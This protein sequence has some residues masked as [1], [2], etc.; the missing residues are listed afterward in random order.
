MDDLKSQIRK[1]LEDGDIVSVVALVVRNRRALNMLVRIS[2]AKDTLVG[3]RAIIAAGAAAREIIGAEYEFLRET[4]RKLLWSLTDESGGIGWSAP[5]LLGEI[6]SA[7]P[8]RFADLVPLIASVYGVEEDVFRPG[9]VYALRRIAESAPDL[10]APQ[11]KVVISA[12]CDK[13]PLVRIFGLQLV[14]ALW[15]TAR[16]EKAWSPE[17]QEKVRYRVKQLSNDLGEAWV[18]DNNSFRSAIVKEEASK[19]NK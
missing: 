12:L 10:V 19:I 18:Y 4:C 5:E 9:V 1:G 3:W 6:I 8:K 13:E 17:F 11:Q 15:E 7:D 16:R 2:Y 14:G